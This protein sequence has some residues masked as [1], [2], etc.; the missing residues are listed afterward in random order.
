MKVTMKDIAEALGVSITTVSRALNNR[1]RIGA[2]T[3]RTVKAKAAELGYKLPDEDLKTEGKM[4]GVVFDKRLQSLATDPFY[5]IVMMGVE[6]KCQEFETQ[7]FFHT[8]DQPRDDRLWFLHSQNRLHGL[9]VVGGDIR[10][11]FVSALQKRKIPVVLVDNCLNG[12]DVDAVV[13]DNAG[14]VRK[15]LNHL[16]EL[17]HEKIGFVGGPL[18][19]PSL[20]ERYETYC[21][22]LEQKG[23]P[24][25]KEWS[26]IHTL[27][28]PCVSQGYQAI[29]AWHKQGLPITALLTDN[30]STAIGVLRGCTEVGLAVPGDLS[31]VGFDDIA[32]AE[33]VS[34]GI[35][36]VHIHK[37]AMGEWAAKRLHELM[38]KE[39]V[40]VR[41]TLSTELV[42]RGSS[43]PVQVGRDKES[44]G[45]DKKG[46]SA[47]NDGGRP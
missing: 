7:V 33:H 35:T 19:H 8:V 13:T 32:L 30:D 38:E 26:W 1:G 15:I 29:Q 10:N 44:I 31:I 11:G 46:V 47:Y 6:K 36:S 40:P 22:V 39:D 34:P 23:L 3:K 9:I 17:G 18:S 41:I 25:K 5:S 37:M 45:V 20:A 16:C 2:A 43:G 27:P 24:C 28:G 14:G 42:V 12:L 4:V 21:K